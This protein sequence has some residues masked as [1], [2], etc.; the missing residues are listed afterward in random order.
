MHKTLEKIKVYSDEINYEVDMIKD[1]KE[2]K[3]IP[4]RHLGTPKYYDNLKEVLS[5]YQNLGY[6][7]FYE[8]M[9]SNNTN[10]IRQRKFRKILPLKINLDS[11]EQLNY[12]EIL[13]KKFRKIDPNFE[14][15]QNV[16]PQPQYNFLITDLN[17]SKNVDIT[18]EEFVNEYER[19]NGA[20][21]LDSCDYVNNWSKSNCET[22]KR[23]KGFDKILIDYR[24]N[25]V[26]DNVLS[27]TNNKI[28]ILYGEGHVKGIKK[29]LLKNGYKLNK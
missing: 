23:A 6:V 18:I 7:V 15:K 5:K 26:V 29:G 14:F 8:F 10:D 4:L 12:K 11:K 9:R 2:L 20:V 28:L 19:L 25:N 16:I 13:L 3:I 21:V 1:N 24:N 27:A 17:N 22:N